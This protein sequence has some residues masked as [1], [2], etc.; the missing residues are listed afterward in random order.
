[1]I[2]RLEW[3][4]PIALEVLDRLQL[5]VPDADPNRG[6]ADKDY[7]PGEDDDNDDDYDYNDVG[8]DDDTERHVDINDNDNMAIILNLA[9][10]DH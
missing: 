10:L 9:G 5:K 7:V 1:M 6:E 4:Y 2:R 3:Q 8:G